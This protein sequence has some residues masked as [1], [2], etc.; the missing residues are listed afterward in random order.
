MSQTTPCAAITDAQMEQARALMR[1]Q[2]ALTVTRAQLVAQEGIARR[3]MERH[4]RFIGERC[5]FERHPDRLASIA[6]LFQAQHPMFQRRVQS[7]YRYFLRTLINPIKPFTFAHEPALPTPPARVLDYAAITP[8]ARPALLGAYLGI[9][10]RNRL[11]ELDLV[12]SRPSEGRIV[13]LHTGGPVDVAQW[14]AA[15]PSLNAWL[16]GGIGGVTWTITDH[17]AS[18]LL[19]VR[20]TA[21]PALIP[22]DRRILKRGELFVGIDTTL[23]TP[24]T[25]SFRDLSAGTY[26]PGM[27]GTGKTSAVHILLRSI[28]AN[29]DLFDAVWLVDGKDGV[30]FARY[31][32]LHPKKIR[33]IYEEPDFWKL[34]ADLT[35]T[36]R[37]RNAQQRAQGI[38]KATSGLIAVVVD[39][40]PT[41]IAD[42]PKA[43]KYDHAAFLDNLQRLAMR[44]RS[45][46]IKMFFISQ[47]PVKEQIPVTLRSN[48]ATTICFRLPEQAHATA[49]FG[50]LKDLPADPRKLET[51]R[52]LIQQGDTGRITAVQFPFAE[53]YQPK[54]RP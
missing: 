31:A 14:R 49:V 3:A 44:G 8:D 48:C 41:F 10:Q 5:A 51:G 26:I 12:N 23:R 27:S 30:A 25:I 42:P 7:N 38:D 46:G 21:L 34:A 33:V 28:F 35:V 6:E 32:N 19:L 15:L 54:A 13:M 1:V 11:A 53:L 24:V 43:Q 52:A 16:T 47:S 39:E 40:L 2:H 17:N 29:L 22:F 45:A 18:R 9:H 4:T 37:E 50:E 36:M 20:Q